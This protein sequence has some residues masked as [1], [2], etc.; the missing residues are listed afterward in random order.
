M[1]APD[2]AVIIGLR[3]IWN[4]F[5]VA[6]NGKRLCSFSRFAEDA[7]MIRSEGGMCM[8]RFPL[9]RKRTY[10]TTP[11]RWHMWQDRRNAQGFFWPDEKR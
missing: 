9:A 4:R 11:T 2:D 8:G 1:S 10:Y 5:C 6:S 7:E 3:A